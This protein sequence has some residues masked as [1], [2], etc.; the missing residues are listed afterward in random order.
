MYTHMKK[1]TWFVEG[2]IKSYFPSIDHDILMRLLGKRIGDQRILKLI[3]TGLKAKI[4]TE[5]K[6]EIIPELGTPQ[7]GILSPLLSNIYLHQ[8]D[9]FMEDMAEKLT[10]KFTKRKRNQA[11]LRLLNKGNKSEYYGKRIPY[12]VPNDSNHV[13]VKY[14]R[15]ADDF[16]IAVD[17][18]RK[19]ADSLRLQVKEFLANE[20]RVELSIEKTH[21]THISKG[22]PFLGYILGRRTVFTKQRY[23]GKILNRRM[24]IPLLSVDLHRVIKRLAIAGYCTKGGDPRPMFK[25]LQLPQSETNKK[26]NYILRG[27]SE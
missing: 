7:G 26:I 21:I 8:L 2:D 15:Y 18:S 19:L 5:E 16:I 27:L 14:I 11:A 24:S 23:N 12:Y 20:L 6:K 10:T 13:K 3:K 4:F 25:F 17:G 1:M 22:V 9:L